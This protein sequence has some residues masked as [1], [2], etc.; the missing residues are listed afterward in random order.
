MVAPCP[1]SSFLLAHKEKACPAL[2]WQEDVAM[3]RC[4]MLLTPGQYC[5]WLPVLLTRPFIFLVRRWL[6]L[7]IG[8]DC[9]VQV[10]ISDP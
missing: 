4:G 5:S 3:Y 1:V 10:E 2:V 8:C 9:D 7:D 6:A